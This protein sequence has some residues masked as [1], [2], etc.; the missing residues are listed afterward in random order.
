MEVKKTVRY[1]SHRVY[2]PEGKVDVKEMNQQLNMEF[3]LT[4]SAMKKKK[5]DE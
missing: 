2:S 1:L 3:K 4:V 5:W